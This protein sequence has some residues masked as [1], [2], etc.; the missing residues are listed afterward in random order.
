LIL[1]NQD[2]RIFGGKRKIWANWQQLATTGNNR[3]QL[4]TTGN[5]WQHLFLPDSKFIK[6][7]PTTFVPQIIKKKTLNN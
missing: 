6:K 1:K 7:K 4:A 5:N 3:Q 2:F